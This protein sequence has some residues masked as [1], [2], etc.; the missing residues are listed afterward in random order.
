MQA[1][2]DKP[3]AKEKEQACVQLPASVSK[4]AEM[5]RVQTALYT[6]QQNPHLG[7]ESWQTALYVLQGATFMETREEKQATPPE[8]AEP[9]V[10]SPVCLL[11]QT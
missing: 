5:L 9:S 2:T 10:H 8:P 1:H 6:S 11:F 3:S 4:G 7:K